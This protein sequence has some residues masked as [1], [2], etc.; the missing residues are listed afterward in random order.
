MKNN[1]LKFVGVL[2]LTSAVFRSVSLAESQYGTVSRYQKDWLSGDNKY[3]EYDFGTWRPN[4]DAW[5]KAEVYGGNYASGYCYATAGTKR[6]EDS[7]L[8][9]IVEISGVDYFD[10]GSCAR[11]K[12][13]DGTFRLEVTD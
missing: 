13:S 4:D 5:L 11:T 8:Y 7:G 12:N 3:V 9:A 10:A 1:I 6:A 2:T